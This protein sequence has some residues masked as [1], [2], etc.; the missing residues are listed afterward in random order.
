MLP[1]Q[2]LL[3]LYYR[4]S[5]GLCIQ[6]PYLHALPVS[7]PLATSGQTFYGLFLFHAVRFPLSLLLIF[8]HPG[9]FPATSTYG[10]VMECL[11]IFPG[12]V[13]SFPYWEISPVPH[14]SGIF[15]SLKQVLSNL[16]VHHIPTNSA[17]T[18]IPTHT[19]S[20][21]AALSFF[22]FFNALS[23]SSTQ[24]SSTLSS[25]STAQSKSSSLFSLVQ[26]CLEV[27]LPYL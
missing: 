10:L 2:F 7:S 1:S 15:P 27:L 22:I 9:F 14:S 5:P 16:Y 20:M 6:L 18:S 8:C 25:P 24:I 4:L 11:Y 26:Q 12:R 19:S 13:L 23:I 3:E 21:P 17:T